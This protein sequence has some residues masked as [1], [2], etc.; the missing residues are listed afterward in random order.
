MAIAPSLQRTVA[1]TWPSLTEPL[2]A[3]TVFEQRCNCTTTACISGAA[4]LRGMERPRLSPT[5]GEPHAVFEVDR[6]FGF[7]VGNDSQRGACSERDLVLQH[8]L[9]VP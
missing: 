2:V 6:V 7:R 5:G 8:G 3:A 1:K 4:T 9:T